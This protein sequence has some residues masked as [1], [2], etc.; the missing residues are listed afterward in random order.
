[1]FDGWDGCDDKQIAVARQVDQLTS[2]SGIILPPEST[3]DDFKLR[4]DLKHLGG[5]L[6]FCLTPKPWGH[7]R[8]RICYSNELKH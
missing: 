3:R 7:D 5:G 2:I 8:I 1:M 6:L 4:D